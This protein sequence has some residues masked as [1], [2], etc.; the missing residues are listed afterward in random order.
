MESLERYKKVLTEDQD[1]SSEFSAI[2]RELILLGHDI[3]ANANNS[4][5]SKAVAIGSAALTLFS[6]GKGLYDLYKRSNKAPTYSIKIRE[7]DAIF[8]IVEQWFMASFPQEKQL[9]VYAHSSVSR[10]RKTPRR[11][12]QSSEVSSLERLFGDPG[13]PSD[14]DRVTIDFTFDGTV[15]QTLNIAGYDVEVYTTVPEGSASSQT[16]GQK[17]SWSQRSINIVCKTVEARSAVRQEIESKAQYLAQSQPRMFTSTRW[18]DMR[19][20]TE[21]Q[22]RSLESV[23][24]KE[25]QMDRIMGYLRGFL[26]NKEAY[27]KAD[28]A[29]RTG[30]LLYGAP[31][32][33]KSSTALA[34]AN[35]LR[36]NVYII[37]L[38]ALTSDEALNDCFNNIPHNSIIILEDIDVASAVRDRETEEGDENGVTM[39]G[40]LNV[41]DGFQSPP[42]VITIMTT[43]RKDVLDE[44]I[45]RPGRVDLEEELSCLDDFQLRGMCEY[46]M[47]TVPENLP[48]I[49]P[50]DGISSASVM[51]VIR[52]HLPDFENASEDMVEFILNEKAK[53]LEPLTTVE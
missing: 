52:K 33:G 8:D 47:G 46:F 35:E 36:M 53:N 22:P 6:A 21:I 32:S 10:I 15:V 2:T 9:S 14:K 38:S 48:S 13:D 30:I 50:E 12:G 42:G 5:L 41:L 26:D 1:A 37:S 51:G 18:G 20:R 29:Y 7:D 11:R 31:G 43:N 34:I 16:M 25:G 4:T 17:P 39:S 44:A 3:V 24:L 40:M 28:L 27:A 19:K 23:V 49:T 45:R